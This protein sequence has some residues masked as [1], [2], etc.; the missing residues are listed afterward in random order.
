MD[1]NDLVTSRLNELALEQY[2]LETSD[3]LCIP[4]V[5]SA[6]PDKA[7]LAEVKAL[8]TSWEAELKDAVA[9]HLAISKAHFESRSPRS[10]V[11]IYPFLTLLSEDAYVNLI[12]N[13]VR[14]LE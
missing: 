6:K 8:E 13:E 5:S 4:S 3:F 2:N 12:L 10:A 1:D 9:R 7:A 14:S 11:H